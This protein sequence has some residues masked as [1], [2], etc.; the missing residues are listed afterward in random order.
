ML[1]YYDVNK[2]I[3]V[4]NTAVENQTK[5]YILIALIIALCL[6]IYFTY[7]S[8]MFTDIKKIGIRR[9]IG[10]TRKDIIIN[11][12]LTT[13][14][15]SIFTICIGFVFAS[16]FYAVFLNISNTV[17]N[18]YTASFYTNYLFYISF[19][20]IMILNIIFGCL[21]S[22]LLMRKTPSEII[23]KYDI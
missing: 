21:P 11:Y 4:H 2:D 12:A 6:Y 5:I 19:I 10:E 17:N 3:I 18:V 1:N 20:G 23:A 9:A 13:F 8:R 7:R 22:V 16:I 14:I 15:E